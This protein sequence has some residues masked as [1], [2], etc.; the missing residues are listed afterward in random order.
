MFLV[1]IYTKII[2]YLYKNIYISHESSSSSNSI[3]PF[4]LQIYQKTYIIYTIL[5]VILRRIWINLIIC[6]VIQLIIAN[7]LI[8]FL[9][10]NFFIL[11]IFIKHRNLLLFII[12]LILILFWIFILKK[13]IRRNFIT[14]EAYF[15]LLSIL[16]IIFC[17]FVC[18]KGPF[19]PINCH[20]LD[21]FQFIFLF[22]AIKKQNFN[23]KKKMYIFLYYK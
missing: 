23:F 19:Y 2:T 9:N 1:K 8:N 20:N 17:N 18:N 15:K 7:L 5:W 6:T 3:W 16:R 21:C 10:S 12:L 4:I 14:I 13:L 11:L 22:I